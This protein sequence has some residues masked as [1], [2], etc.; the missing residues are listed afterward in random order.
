[1]PFTPMFWRIVRRL[2]TA[3]YGR[4]FVILLALGA[5]AAVTAALLNLQIDAKRR[6]TT[7]FRALGANV[8]V[9]PRD[10]SNSDSNGA[11]LD[12]ALLAQL[13]AENDGKH[14]P[15]VAFLYVIGEVS[16]A[17]TLHYE[18]A[19]IAGTKGQGLA[20][21]RPGRRTEFSASD[22]SNSTACEVGAKAAAQFG[23]HA[24]DTLLL[25]NHG[26]ESSCKIFSVVAIGGAEDTQ[27]FTDLATAQSLASLPGRI[28]LIQL[29]VTGTPDSINRFVTDLARRIPGAD[30][31]G[32]RQFAEAE[33]RIYNR[34]SGLLSSTVL[35]VLLLTSLCVMAGMSNVAIERRNDV[36]LM[37]AIG[38]SVRRVVRLFLA[39]AIILGI[40][41]GVVG[42]AAGLLV[43]IWL[44][45]AVFGV[46][47]EPRWIVYPFSVALTI[48]VSIASAFPLRRLA[49]I[50]PASVFRG[51][52]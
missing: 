32:I 45:K 19:V 28:S 9:A 25:R 51:E 4:L 20:N 15:A 44:G 49:S 30:V 12:E 50:R 14:V 29:S 41:G 26:R 8:I 46:A 31:H 42:S 48:L 1:M 35:L 39:E 16:K 38:G 22:E 37:K 23:V 18:P 47:A 52:G 43:S 5:G 10:T 40:A 3:N 34:I 21:V 13:P 33:G 6:L 27:I 2:L 24:G 7:E 11:T 36:G 17:G